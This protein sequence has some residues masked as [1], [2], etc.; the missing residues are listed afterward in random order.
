MRVALYLRDVHRLDPVTDPAIPVLDPPATAW[1]AWVRRPEESDLTPISE[2]LRRAAAG[3]WARWW[4][5]SLLVDPGAAARDLVPPFRGFAHVP[6]LR[7]LLRRDYHTAVRWSEA[8]A[9][10]PRLKR[11]HLAPGT[12]LARLVAELESVA[13]RDSRPFTLDISVISVRTKH[14]WVIAPDRLLITH[15]LI[16]DDENV[17][18]WLRPRIRELV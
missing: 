16:R 12:Q 14:A 6:E 18:D 7:A 17:L 10:D 1:P 2:D 8:F 13:G 11:D 9:D 15:H 3:Q 5:Q 4:R